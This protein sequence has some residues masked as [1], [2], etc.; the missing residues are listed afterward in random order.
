M[1]VPKL[2][3]AWLREPLF[4][5]LLIGALL[6]L[7]HD[8][9]NEGE[10]VAPREIVVSEARIEALAENFAA[11]WM[12]PPTPDELKGLVDDFVAEE[13]YYREGLA[14]GL[15]R[16]DTVIR[17]RLRQ[18]L[19]F[20]SADA[21]AAQ[22]PSE[23]QLQDFLDRYAERFVEP[24]RLTFQQVF[25]STERRGDATRRD[26]ERLLAELQADRGTADPTDAGDST[27]LPAEMESASPQDIAS[28]FG[29]DFASQLDEAV[30]GQWTGPLQSAYGL[31]LVRVAHRRAGARPTLAEIRPLVAREWEAAQRSRVN[32]E[33]LAG[34]AARYEIRVEGPLG[35]LLEQ[36]PQVARP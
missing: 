9:V 34:L 4:H 19:E 35:D 26:A 2:H 29:D 36:T 17:R 33:F 8:L 12:R 30:V 11:T 7:L 6:F 14:M 5:F 28:T 25:L 27:M 20:I 1:K 24:S 23:V 21:A 10:S 32:A 31:H 22:V 16:D 18:K 13:I 3:A 15:D